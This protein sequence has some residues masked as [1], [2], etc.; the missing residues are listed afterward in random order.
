MTSEEL[1]DTTRRITRNC[2]IIL[3]EMTVTAAALGVLACVA[4]LAWLSSLG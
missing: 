4:A 1:K 2:K 3:L